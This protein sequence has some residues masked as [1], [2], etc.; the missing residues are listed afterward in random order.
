MAPQLRAAAGACGRYGMSNLRLPI[1]VQVVDKVCAYRAAAATTGT[2]SK[3]GSHDLVVLFYD[4]RRIFTTRFA[5]RIY[6]V[7]VI[8]NRT[9]SVTVGPVRVNKFTVEKSSGC[10]R[11]TGLARWIT[12]FRVF[13][14]ES[15]VVRD[16]T[17][18]T[19]S[20]P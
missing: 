1:N 4:N 12:H 14:Y 16:V 3:D 9:V 6:H 5:V 18:L 19:W 10:L 7:S 8:G 11:S 13:G 17:Y 15:T 2:G 20:L